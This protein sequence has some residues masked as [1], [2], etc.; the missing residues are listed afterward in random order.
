MKSKKGYYIGTS[1]E[2]Y[3]YYHAYIPETNGIQ[4]SETMYFKHKCITMQSLTPADVIVQAA[5]EL[6]D[7]LKGKIPPTFTQPSTGQLKRDS[8]TP[9][10]EEQEPVSVQSAQAKYAT[11]AN[12]QRVD[13]SKGV[14]EQRVPT[15]EG[16]HHPRVA[17][18]QVTTTNEDLTRLIVL[19][20]IAASGTKP[21]AANHHPRG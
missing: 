6:V 14:H 1:R 12:S 3:R 15:S 10:M 21:K 5:K 8:F 17:D 7:T 4:W 20:E 19:S 18:D 16:A 9:E 11:D 2:H 13:S